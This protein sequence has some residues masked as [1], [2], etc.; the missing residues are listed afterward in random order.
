[1]LFTQVPVPFPRD[2]LARRH[3]S[4]QTGRH[5]IEFDAGYR[6]FITAPIIPQL[7]GPAPTNQIPIAPAARPDVPLTRDFLPWRLSDA[8]R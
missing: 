2:R 3:L 5:S 7:A 1:M 8:G 4:S 6:S